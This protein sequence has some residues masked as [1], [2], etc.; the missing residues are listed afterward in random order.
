M[1]ESTN[2]ELVKIEE[3]TNVSGCQIVGL[4][5]PFNQNI[6]MY[7]RF[8][9]RRIVQP[10]CA[11]LFHVVLTEALIFYQN[12][13]LVFAFLPSTSSK[14]RKIRKRFSLVRQGFARYLEVSGYRAWL[15]NNT[16]T[17]SFNRTLLERLP[18]NLIVGRNNQK[19]LVEK[20]QRQDQKCE[21]GNVL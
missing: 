10:L 6:L 5:A 2:L 16:V 9:N 14:D 8:L 1:I 21:K 11:K 20:K 12:L 18:S 15:Y 19:R 3:Q 17:S 7:K 4:N 13:F